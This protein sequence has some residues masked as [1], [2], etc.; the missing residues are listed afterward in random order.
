MK[1]QVTAP[2]ALA[3]LL[4]A[5]PVSHAARGVGTPPASRDGAPVVDGACTSSATAVGAT[6]RVML[7]DLKTGPWLAETAKG[8]G[9]I[10]AA[11]AAKVRGYSIISA[12]EVRAALDQEANKS[13]MGCDE[14]SCLAELAQALDAELVISGRI[15]DTSEGNALVSLNVLNARAIVVVNRVNMTWPGEASALTDVVRAAAQ[16][17]MFEPKDRPP[18]TL[19]LVGLPTGAQVFVDGAAHGGSELIEGLAIGPHEIKVEAP[20]KSPWVDHAVVNSGAA[21][22]VTVAMEGEPIDAA[23]LW[24]GGGAAVVLGG[25]AAI[26]VAYALGQSDVVVQAAIP[27]VSANDVESIRGA[28]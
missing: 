23:W 28:K 7:L 24:L 16:T 17:L 3:L 2:F 5:S 12:E 6:V 14:S 21:T 20:G 8:L 15:D 18:G 22:A 26:G 13:M 25:A 4:L 1:R 11:E 9:Q 27:S 19:Q 10:V